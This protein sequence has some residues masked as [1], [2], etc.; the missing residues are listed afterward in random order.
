[1]TWYEEITTNDLIVK[2]DQIWGD[3]SSIPPA[4][5]LA[6]AQANAVANPSIIDDF[7]LAANAIRLTPSPNNKVFFATS[8]YDD[9]ST[10]LRNW[11]MPQLIPRTDLGWEGFPSIGYA[12]KLWDG[13][14][15][16]GGSEIT[17]SE[18]QS[19][20]IVGWWM[21]YGA[22]A[23]K[24]ASSFT[25]ISDPTQV[26]LTGFQYIGAEGSTGVGSGGVTGTPTRIGA[27]DIDGTTNAIDTDISLYT[28]PA[29]TYPA[30]V[31]IIAVNRNGLTV[32]TPSTRIAHVDGAIGAVANEDYLWYDVLLQPNESKYIEIDGM[33]VGDSILV[34]SDTTDVNFLATALYQ[35]TDG[36]YKRIAATTVV[37]DTDTSLFQAS[38]S[39]YEDCSIHI[40]NKDASN[41]V[42]YRV[43]LIDGAVGAIAVE[44]YIIFDE[45][46]TENE[47]FTFTESFHLPDGYTV[48]VRA[49]DADVNFLLYGRER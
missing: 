49:S 8:V 42:T 30:K 25:G 7:S 24:V 5:N 1:M 37:A 36:G 41:A 23:I 14:P 44:D 46:I 11:I 3:Y 47:G 29:S 6:T 18:E 40:C 43:A 27:E 2:P 35:T 4:P 28:V 31:K 48:A 13:D 21:N 19:G 20:A 17:T 26:Y 10:R 45:L 33:E 16:A 12:V 9:L 34:R 38:G 32:P 15:N 39:D 22:G